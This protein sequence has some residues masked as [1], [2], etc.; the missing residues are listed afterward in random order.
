MTRHVRH[1]GW[2]MSG[3]RG[4][5]DRKKVL[6]AAELPKLGGGEIKEVD[7]VVDGE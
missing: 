5:S 2:N 4:E 1:H 3:A 7:V 6:T